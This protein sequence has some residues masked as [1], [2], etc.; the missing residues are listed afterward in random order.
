M[1]EEALN[2]SMRKLL[3]RFGVTSQQEIEKALRE[4]SEAGTL[5]SSKL[6]VH[7]TLT[8]PGIDLRHEI[9]GEL[10]LEQD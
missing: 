2:T 10:K 1:D 5:D 7:V 9:D 8:V 4:A 3:K 6:D